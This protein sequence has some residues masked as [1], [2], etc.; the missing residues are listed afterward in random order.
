MSD[1]K[2]QGSSA[3][4]VDFLYAALQADPR[5]ANFLP[6]DQDDVTLELQSFLEDAFDESFPEFDV[7]ELGPP[8]V[9]LDV[10]AEGLVR[11]TSP[12][13]ALVVA[14][15]LLRTEL[16]RDKRVQQ[17]LQDVRHAAGTDEDP[18]LELPDAGSGEE[19]HTASLERFVMSEEQAL[20]V[21]TAWR[22]Y[23]DSFSDPDAAADA[24]FTAFYE[25]APSL[26]HLFKTARNTMSGR[27]LSGI[28]QIITAMPGGQETKSVVELIGF[29]HLD[30]EV[31]SPRVAVFREAILEL[32]QGELGDGL[33]SLA[34]DGLRRMLNYAGGGFIFMRDTFAERLNIL[35]VSWAI[36]SGGEVPEFED[37]HSGEEGSMAASETKEVKEVKDSDATPKTNLNMGQQSVP[38]TFNEMFCFNAAVMGL[39]D[40]EW[41]FE[42]LDSFD[43]IVKSIANTFRL[44]EECDVISLR[45]AKLPGEIHLGEF[46]AVMLASLRS[47]VP[48]DWDTKHEVAWDWLW[49]NVQRILV[50][51]IG[52]P[53]RR[54]R[55]VSRYVGSLEQET[56]EL[57][58]GKVYS[59][60]FATAPEG[61][62]F[63]KQSSSRLLFIVERVLELTLDMYRNPHGMVDDISALGLR[64]VGYGIPTHFFNPFVAAVLDGLR[65]ITEDE[66]L[67]EAFGWSL[68]LIAR[69]LVRTITEGSTLVMKAIN[70]NSPKQIR[71]ALSTAPRNQRAMWVLKVTVGTQSISPLLWAI[72]SGS[73]EAAKAIMR[74]L[75]TIRADRDHY[76]YGVDELF[77]RHPDIVQVITA[78]AP[79]LLE[80]MLDKLVW[81]S[82]VVIGGMRRAN[83]FLK[84]LLIDPDGNFADAMSWICKMQDPVIVTHDVLEKLTDLVWS[85]VIYRPFLLSKVWLLFTLVVFLFSQAILKNWQTEGDDWSL[86]LSTFLCRCF[87]Y[88]AGMLELV[89]TRGKVACKAIKTGDITRVFQIPVPTKYVS[90][91]QEGVSVLLTL[92]LIGMYMVEPIMFC[93]DNYEGD[94]QGAGLFTQNCP[95]A[96]D[97][98]DLYALLSML[99]MFCYFALLVDF[100]ALFVRSSTFVMIAGRVAPNLV[101]ALCAG[102]YLVVVF[103]TAVT[104]STKNEDFRTIP[105]AVLSLFQMTVGMYPGDKYYAVLT[106]RWLLV[107]CMGLIILVVIFLFNVLIAMLIGSYSEVHGTVIGLARLNRMAIIV[108]SMPGVRQKTFAKFIEGLK[109]D[110]RM[111]FNEGDVGLAGG[112]DFV[113]P[114]YVHPTYEDLICRFGGS[115][116]P[117]MPW[118]EDEEEATGSV[119]ERLDDL[120]KIFK[121]AMKRIY[122]QHKHGKS[123]S[124]ITSS[125]ASGSFNS[126]GVSSRSD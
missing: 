112:I 47:L 60:F 18:G 37:M 126:S 31:S 86:R 87:V 52:V 90:D 45:F 120:T 95:A 50:K 92:I 115:T 74:D 3:A 17:F 113:E 72:Q 5:F 79:E 53:S 13:T 117:K 98:H 76:Y 23:V 122:L 40:R 77:E 42:V 81:R 101:L 41:M 43:V 55:L 94:F 46:K 44:Q 80:V 6:A 64:H 123:E 109:L 2:A 67:C 10:L 51:E 91:W 118:P 35:A 84:H 4:V 93:L 14:A 108:D 73:M 30:L 119:C 27:F 1:A 61:Q 21:Q 71:K 49:E 59:R 32:L 124:S 36:A 22:A 99:A 62:D 7:L 82:R 96:R 66:K 70:H 110:E 103:G 69:M 56:R 12:G 20:E 29:R 97:V 34:Y 105:R 104:V 116:S 89:Y 114:A 11:S 19:I 111:E 102:A 121:K 24:L 75:L 48:K 107:M 26:Q 63:F 88:F 106:D 38:T 68:G 33:S 125:E 16:R 15:S 25:A 39:S 85:N 58:S 65:E 28:E 54:E 100:S 9:L 78:E 8:T 83:I 57:L